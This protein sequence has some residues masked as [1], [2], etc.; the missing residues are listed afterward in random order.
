MD[1]IM[2]FLYIFYKNPAKTFWILSTGFLIY[3]SLTVEPNTTQET[4][5]VGE[6]Y[7][8]KE[9]YGYITGDNGNGFKILPK[10]GTTL[11]GNKLTHQTYGVVFLLSS[12]FGWT[13]L[14]LFLI[15][16]VLSWS[17]DVWDYDDLKSEYL[18]KTIKSYY[19]GGEYIYIFRGRL[20]HKSTNVASARS[21]SQMINKYFELKE[22]FP[23][24]T[25]V[26]VKREKKLKEILG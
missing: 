4:E 2:S 21:L 17:E 22:L 12:I 1:R 23:V 20:I 11:N 3:L 6:A 19:E 13:S 26:E 10:E 18:V 14:L 9:L 25:P 7:I 5:V 24:Y 8:N 15:F 16:F